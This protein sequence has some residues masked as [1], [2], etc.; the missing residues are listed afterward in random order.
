MVWTRPCDRCSTVQHNCTEKWFWSFAFPLSQCFLQTINRTHPLTKSLIS[1]KLPQSNFLASLS[2]NKLRPKSWAWFS[3]IKGK[4]LVIEQW[5]SQNCNNVGQ[6]KSYPSNMILVTEPFTKFGTSQ[7]SCFF[8][9]SAIQPLGSV[10]SIENAWF[11]NI[12][13]HNLWHPITY[14]HKWHPRKRR[15]SYSVINSTLA[16]S[17]MDLVTVY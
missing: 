12:I 11:K 5:G 13:S 1:S 10:K 7:C 3:K 2:H 16:Y 17:L 15:Q 9:L 14:V 8:R 6:R 4:A